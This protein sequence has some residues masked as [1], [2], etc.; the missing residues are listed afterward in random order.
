V[1]DHS[2]HGAARAAGEQ[3]HEPHGAA[4]H[5]D[6]GHGH[7]RLGHAGHADVYRRRF[8]I[9]LILA[10][11]VVAYSEMIQ[12]WFGFTAPQFP[13][14]GLVAP[15]LS[16]VIFFYGGSV[17][18]TGA[19]SE[20]RQRA[21]GMMLLVSLAISV[22]FLTSAASALRL[23]DL[24]FWWELS[25]LVVIM[26]LGHWQEM[27]ALSQARGA[28]SALA[29]L[30]PDE[31]ERL[32][33]GETERVPL[34]E[35]RRGDLVLVRPGARVPADGEIVAGEAELDESMIT[36][37]SKP[38]PKG[39]G[40]EVTAG[41]VATDSAIRVRVAA[42]GE[43]T[44]LAGIQRLV[45][46][47][48][49]SRSRTQALADRAAALL[50]YVAVAAAVGAYVVWAA[51]GDVDFGVISAVSVLVISCP[52]ALGLAIP[53]VIS[54]STSLAS[55][56][57][58]LVKDRLSLERSRLVD[59]V[60]FD[61]TG[62]LTRG[63][64]V[65]TGVAGHDRDAVLA[66]AGAVEAESEHPL[67][68]AIV[69][70]ARE[71]GTIPVAH[72]F[73]AM[74]GRGVEASLNGTRVAV[75]GPSLLRE[76][77]LNVPDE[78]RRQTAPWRSRGASVLYL[79]RDGTVVG[80][81]A[82]EDRVRPE[83][84]EAVERLHALGI[85]VAM[86]TGDARQVAEAVAADLG[87]DEVFAEVLPEDKEQH[88]RELQERG[89]RVAMVGDGVND[90]P[91][92]AR[93]DV[94]IAIGAGTDVAIESA[95]VVLASDDPRAVVGVVRLSRASYAKMVQNLLWAAGY[96]IVAIPVA[97]GVLAPWGIMMPPAVGALL[98][99]LSTIVVALNAQLL[100]RL[101][102]RPG[103]RSPKSREASRS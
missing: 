70:A 27:K 51:L 8:W 53:L 50:F 21:P 66:Q 24:E 48:Q 73:H 17:F 4:G 41:T 23:F 103:A 62:T 60:L 78:L 12:D 92:L 57:G 93:A 19:W 100:R 68:R 40:E 25:A 15:V 45:A 101:D 44:A 72:D 58:I 38:V 52:H 75:G 29:E 63:E 76:R 85:R 3:R 90:A 31:A 79:V 34:D 13:G 18:L 7:E 95:G 47:A 80:A 77:S 99:S 42:V 94:G 82:L 1:N 2:R 91:A 81:F 10:V 9:S 28:L 22:A 88:V 71:R 6:H 83:A 55:R 37:E 33:D 69:S 43:E 30:L 32:R 14:D 26:L 16:T 35:L 5:V 87:I 56:S 86:I 84:R 46:E 54:I 59:V 67:A 65:V 49:A 98:M 20:L 64:H 74:S 61:K 11:P 97:A 96:N 89:R 39:E 102:L 36:G